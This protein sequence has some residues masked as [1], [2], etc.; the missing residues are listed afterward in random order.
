[1]STLGNSTVKPTNAE[2]PGLHAMERYKPATSES[3][4]VKGHYGPHPH[5]EHPAAYVA[6]KTGFNATS[7]RQ[8]VREH[9]SSHEGSAQLNPDRILY[10]S[11]GAVTAAVPNKE[12]TDNVTTSQTIRYETS[13]QPSQEVYHPH[14]GKAAQSAHVMNS[15]E[16]RPS[17]AH[18]SSSY[19]QKPFAFPLGPVFATSS[20]AAAS[21]T[22]LPSGYEP[23][24]ARFIGASQLAKLSASHAHQTP[25][26]TVDDD[27]PLPTRMAATELVGH[28]PLRAAN[29]ANEYSQDVPASTHRAASELVHGVPM[30]ASGIND[31][32]H[33]LD[34]AT[35][36]NINSVAAASYVAARSRVIEEE[37]EPPNEV[38]E[39]MDY[40]ADAQRRIRKMNVFGSAGAALRERTQQDLMANEQEHSGE[41][42]GFSRN[43][44]NT[45]AA[46]TT[47]EYKRPTSSYT[48]KDATSKVYRSNTY[49]PKS[50]VNGSVYRSKSVKSTTSHNKVPERNS[51]PAYNE[52][53]MHSSAANA[54]I[55]S[56]KNY[57]PPVQPTR[58]D[59]VSQEDARV[60]EIVRGMKLPLTSSSLSAAAYRPMEKQDPATVE[61]H[62]IQAEATQRVRDMKL[63]LTK[64][65]SKTNDEI[66]SYRPRN[67]VIK[68][69]AAATPPKNIPSTYRA[70]QAPSVLSPVVTASEG[71]FELDGITPERQQTM[72]R[73]TYQE[74]SQRP[75]HEDP[76][77]THPGLLQAVARNHRNSLANIDERIMRQN[78]AATA[79]TNTVSETDIEALE[80][81][82]SKAYRMEAQEEAYAI[83]IGGGRVISPEELEEI[84]RRNVDPMVSELSE[85]AAQERE[86]K[87]QAKEAKRLKKLAKE[88]KR[89]KKKEEKA[90]KAEEKRLQKERAKYAKQMSRESAHADQAIANTG[91]VAPP[92]FEHET[93][94]SHY[95]E[96][97]EEE[98]EERREESSHFS[99]SSGNNEFEETEQEYTHGYGN[100]VLVQRTDVVNNFGESSHAH[101]NA[102][103]EKRDLGRNG[104]GDVDEQDA[105]EVYRHSI[106][107]IVPGD[108][109]H[110]EKTRDTLTRESPA[111]RSEEAVVEVADED[112]PHASEAERAH[113]Y[114]NR[115]QASSESSPESQSTHYNDY[116]GTEDNIVRQTTTVDEDGHQEQTTSTT[117]VAH[118]IPV[119]NGLSSPPRERLDDNAK[120][121]LSRSSPKSP[122]AWFKR[123][124]KNRKDKAAVKRMLEEDSSKQLSSGRDV[125]APTSVNH[126]VSH[127]G[128]STKP[129]VN[130]STKPVAVTSKN[131][132]SRNGSHAAHSNNVIGTQPHVNVSAVPNT[133]NLKDA[134]EGSAVSKTDDVDNVVSGHSNVNGVS[135]SR[136]NIVERSEDYVISHLPEQSRAPIGAAFQEDL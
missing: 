68:P 72:T 57:S 59:E 66:R 47:Y 94:P 92:Y 97:E 30:R 28:I 17:S 38:K 132:H 18:V 134:L 102:V 55:L 87:E 70:P 26:Q 113:S 127:V 16:S 104:F 62:H 82:L 45:A 130:N 6:A 76:F 19:T 8:S 50:S 84:A 56:H 64:L 119:S 51:V 20:Q 111:F 108:Y 44:T 90:R 115:K 11:A 71:D 65:E 69:Y 128:E 98:P 27:V 10:M 103:N 125:V 91:P 60:K 133:G 63:D 101:D 74:S 35:R 22:A 79:N 23:D 29:Y 118:P 46:P 53:L 83:N 106:E 73:S 110:D 122:V 1:M 54:A 135:K 85:R 52:K 117:K 41:F 2:F 112:H 123:K 81:R 124:F 126:D 37:E 48:A 7:R 9:H 40:E 3:L 36:H 34:A 93:E 89:L 13:S 15:T 33:D 39:R 136:P 58:D 88:E 32:K 78:Q 99:E 25:A 107:R 131:G 49:K 75:F 100:D 21:E 61:R 121:I 80:R 116:E 120:E 14:A 12:H 109:L 96:E 5:K 42:A 129:A 77:R 31:P 43:L 95:E 114:S 105:T 67:V 4:Y 86:R 24:E